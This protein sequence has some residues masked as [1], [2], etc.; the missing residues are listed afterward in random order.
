MSAFQVHGELAK[1]NEEPVAPFEL[2]AVELL[3]A[4]RLS[5]LLDATQSLSR[6]ATVLL[7]EANHPWFGCSLDALTPQLQAEL[8]DHLRRLADAAE[9]VGESQ[10][11]LRHAW[12][13]PAGKTLDDAEWL[14]DLLEILDDR[15]VVPQNW[16]DSPDFGSI[17]RSAQFTG[18][19]MQTYLQR[20]SLFLGRYN[21]EI[22][23]LDLERIQSEL[24]RAGRPASQRI[25]G[26]EGP[27]DRALKHRSEIVP[28]ADRTT[29]T[30]SRLDEQTVKLAG[31]LGVTTARTVRGA[32][33]LASITAL[34]L[35]NPQP[36]REWF[37]PG[38]LPALLKQAGDARLRQSVLF[39]LRVHLS[40]RVR[41]SFWDLP[42]RDML[43]R[44]EG[45]FRGWTRLLKPAFH[46]DMGSLRQ[47]LVEQAQVGYDEAREVLRQARETLDDGEWL[48]ERREEFITAFGFHF[49]GMETDWESVERCLRNTGAL[50]E[51]LPAPSEPVLALLAGANG[52]VST[53]AGPHAALK[54]ALDEADEALTSLTSVVEIDMHE[55]QTDEVRHVPLATL[56]AWLQRWSKQIAPF[57]DSADQLQQQ[58][59]VSQ[60]SLTV[61]SDDVAE[62]RALLER[63]ATLEGEFAPLRK[64]F[65]SYFIGFETDWATVSEAFAWA[66]QLRAY[67]GLPLPVTFEDAVL[68]GKL[69]TSA[70]RG[71]LMLGISQMTAV[72][73]KLKPHF[74]LESTALVHRCTDTPTSIV[75]LWARARRVQLP[76]L[77]SWIDYREARREAEAAC[78]T[79]FVTTLQRE[80][81]PPEHWRGA[82]M[83]QVYTLWLSRR[84]QQSPALARFRQQRHEEVI[85]EF[86]T[87]DRR[88][89]E[90]TAARIRARL[91][92]VRPAYS[93]Y[94]APRSEPS[95]LMREAGKKRRFRALRELFADLPHLLP[96]LKP[97][98]LMSPLSVAQFLG[99]SPVTFD[100]VIFDEASQILPA[101]AVGAI[102]RGRQVIVV[103]DQQQ[104]PPTAFFTGSLSDDREGESEDEE[105]PE[106]ILDAGIASGL[107]SKPLLWHYRSR[108]EDL[109]AFSSKWF[110][111]RAHSDRWLYESLIT[112][113][114]T[115]VSKRAVEF[116]HVDGGVY[117]RSGQRVNR[118][119]VLIASRRAAWLT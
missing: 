118:V 43:G 109:I 64:L 14:R 69:A 72:L 21:A 4:A 66:G 53:L 116:I 104:L 93:P 26:T 87:L 91:Q 101:G 13:L 100:V 5:K 71:S 55:L 77:E 1:L 7:D 30:L 33:R 29:T 85:R 99:E 110:Y 28:A 119:S 78:L 10:G 88:H 102:G 12:G 24:E 62:A 40:A 117:D 83:R 18:E 38:R 67:C 9:Q 19:H 50:L 32:R 23:S 115:D 35:T 56:S 44:F 49:H 47:H 81:P 46:N 106:S 113:P 97:C 48:L 51:L 58:Q 98:M 16:L 63:K 76:F 89:F 74:D 105:L 42:I 90:G 60:T 82:M 27:G 96:A 57:W 39:D 68:A 73:D 107:P 45:E 54:R 59:R 22:F 15:P 108:H 95:I 37:A 25:L 75:A 31:R 36:R 111:N 2:P 94:A 80:Q 79:G 3:N 6:V 41:Q 8:D 92:A 86:R 112:F 114:T 103:G 61:L 84:Y 11:A 20:R 65:G 34:I 17:M 70:E 52:D